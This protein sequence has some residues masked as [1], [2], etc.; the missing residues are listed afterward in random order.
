MV[1]LCRRKLSLFRF[2]AS[3]AN[4]PLHPA[5]EPTFRFEGS[6]NVQLHRKPHDPSNLYRTYKLFEFLVP[7]KD[8][9]ACKRRQLL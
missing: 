3:T 9:Q 7:L 2:K 5:I 1:G 4:T 6:Q 8:V